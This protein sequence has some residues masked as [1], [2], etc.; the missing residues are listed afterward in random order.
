MH[1]D[2]MHGVLMQ[3]QLELVLYNVIGAHCVHASTAQLH[4]H[5]H[6]LVNC[7]DEN[8]IVQMQRWVPGNSEGNTKFLQCM[9]KTAAN[10]D[11][12]C[13]K[14]STF[15]KFKN[16]SYNFSSSCLNS[17]TALRNLFLS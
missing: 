12:K 10:G 5:T 3:P 16:S 11:M 1:I 17:A 14:L 15:A 2:I 4:T 9:S 6:A 8:S 7:R 13:A